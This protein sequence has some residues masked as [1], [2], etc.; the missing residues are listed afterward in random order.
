M[1]VDWLVQGLSGL[2]SVTTL[3]CNSS[4]RCPLTLAAQRT[5][6]LRSTRT[7]VVS[8]T[9]AALPTHNLFA[10]QQG[11]SREAAGRCNQVNL[12]P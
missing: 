9:G 4:Y 6:P 5:L 3:S 8:S 2:H 1:E 10:Q 7:E 11:S 12:L